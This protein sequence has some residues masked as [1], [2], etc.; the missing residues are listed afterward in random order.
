MKNNIMVCSAIL[1]SGAFLMGCSTKS[2]E[3]GD[4][5][6]GHMDHDSIT[7]EEVIAAQQSWGEGVV[8]IGKAFSEGGDYR[9]VAADHIEKHY[10]YEDGSVLFKP[11]LAATDQFRPDFDGALSYFVTGGIAEDKGFAI[12]PWTNVR[13]ESAGINTYGDTAAAMGNYYFTDT[14]G[15]ETKVEYSFHYVL[16]EDGDLLIDLHHSSLP[17]NP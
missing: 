3:M 4:H 15:V 7:V 2:H 16:D 9:Q 12:K 8:A 13:W 1:A 11:T 10:A 6:H 17:F 14:Q 5:Q